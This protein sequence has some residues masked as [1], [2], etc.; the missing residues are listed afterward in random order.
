MVAER[1]K[2]LELRL[3]GSDARGR[4]LGRPGGVWRCGQRR[5]G[6]KRPRHAVVA[7]PT[8][9]LVEGKPVARPRASEK[10]GPGWPGGSASTRLVAC[11]FGPRGSEPKRLIWSGEGRSKATLQRFFRDL[12]DDQAKRLEAVCCDI[13]ANYVELIRVKAPQAGLLL[14]K[15]H[16][17]RHLLNAM[18]EVRKQEARASAGTSPSC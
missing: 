3:Q 1:A 13:W 17:V 16:V 15:F 5:S 6:R 4:L 2:L 7:H 8:G 9:L 10:R 14:D 12:G 18:N 11:S